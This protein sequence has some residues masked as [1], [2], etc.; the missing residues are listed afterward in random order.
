MVVAL[1]VPGAA[2]A[3]A[4]KP[5]QPAPKAAAKAPDARELNLQA[6]VELMRSDLRKQKVALIT[7]VMQFTEDEDRKF[8][9][10]YREYE[11]ELGRIND[12]RLQNI[13][14]Y[15][16][17]FSALNDAVAD[18]LMTKALDLEARRAALKQKFY[19]KLKTTISP[20]TAARAL[21]VES[22]ILLLLDLQVA[23]SLPIAE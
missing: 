23:A 4:T 12:E 5:A 6:Y 8:W 11:A 16:R 9:P 3:Q 14:T 10:V 18:Q 1:L 22:Q 21:Q 15:S 2:M 20:L 7:E 13:E 19:S 17:S